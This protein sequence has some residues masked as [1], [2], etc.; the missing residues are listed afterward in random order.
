LLAIDE[1]SLHAPFVFD[2]YQTVI[3]DKT[4]QVSLDPVLNLRKSLLRSHRQ[5]KVTD[6]G[7]G[8]AKSPTRS[9]SGMAK[10]S[11]QPKVSRWLFNLCHKYKPKTVLELGTN[12][13]LSTMSMAAGAENAKIVTIEGCPET[14]KAAKQ[15]FSA[16]NIRHIELITGKIEDVLP[17]VLSHLESIDLL[18]LDAN[19]RYQPTMRYFNQCLPY[20]HS[21]SMVVI[22][23]IHHSS[24]MERAWHEIKQ[25]PRTRLTADLF[26][27]GMV[28][29]DPQ[30]TRAHYTL[31][32]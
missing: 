28:F 9:I 25:L 5:I 23:D 27:A 26:I 1:H 17:E 12:L 14:G 24:E 30:L 7:A 19:H 3:K 20:L 29:F 22:D 2:L 15:H 6:F 16:I 21:L 4:S 10:K 32:F 8:S 11:H 31:E 18:F 13:G